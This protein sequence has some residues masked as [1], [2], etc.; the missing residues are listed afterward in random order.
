VTFRL[1]MTAEHQPVP[2]R[3]EKAGHPGIDAACESITQ[4]RV[5]SGHGNA[6]AVKKLHCGGDGAPQSMWNTAFGMVGGSRFVVVNDVN[7]DRPQQ[8]GNAF[9]DVAAEP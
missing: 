9:R 1:Q 7:A 2:E 8:F 3:R 4:T 5:T 6:L